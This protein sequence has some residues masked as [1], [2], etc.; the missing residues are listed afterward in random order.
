[1]IRSF[2][3]RAVM[4]LGLLAALALGPAQEALTTSANTSGPVLSP[5]VLS[6]QLKE[7]GH[8][9]TDE[10]GVPHIF[11]RNAH[12]LYFM[13]GYVQARDRLFQMDVTRR[14]ASGTLAELLG[15]DALAS[16]VEL[17]TLGLRRAAERSAAQLS[18][19]ARRELEAYTDGINAYIEQAEAKD[20]L[21]PAYGALELTQV[22]PWSV[23]DSL[24][25]AKALAFR[26]SF[27]S[28]ET[29]YTE[30]FLGYSE[31][32]R[33]TG[34]DGATLFNQDLFR[35]EPANETTVLSGDS[36]TSTQLRRHL[37]TR[38]PSS[39][40]IDPTTLEL[41]GDYLDD[42]REISM[43]QPLLK[44]RAIGSNWFVVSG[45]HTAS[46]HPMLA[47]DP[48]LSLTNPAT[49]YEMDQ[50]IDNGTTLDTSGV[51]F[52]GV[53][54]VVLGQT[55]RVAWG[56][57]N[58][59]IDETDFFQEQITQDEQG[60][61]F[62]V[63]RGEREPVRVIPEQYRINRI[64]DDQP[65]NLAP[66]PPGADVPQ[67]TLVAPRHGPIVQ[68]DREA[69][70][71]VSVQFTGF[72]A[73]QEVET[74][75][76]WNRAEGLDDF[77][78]GLKTFDFGSQNWAYAD[79]EGNIAYFASG[80]VPLREDLQQGFVDLIP[81]YLVR[82]G[83]GSL[84]HEWIPDDDP[85]PHQ[86]IP[87]ETLPFEEMPQ[88]VN[89]EKG[90]IVSANNDPLGHTLDND[91]LN[92]QRPSGEGLFYLSRTY[93]DGFRAARLTELIQNEIEADGT[94]S[95]DDAKAIMSDVAQLSA[96][97]LVPH[98]V[99]AL[100][101]ALAEDAPGPL[102]Q[103]ARDP[104][105]AQIR[106]LLA[107]W[108]YT[109]PTGLPS[110]FDEG[111]PAGTPPSP[112]EINAS[113]AATIANVWVPKLVANTVDGALNAISP[114]LPKPTSSGTIRALIHQLETFPENRGVGASGLPLFNVPD[115]DAPAPLERDLILLT[116]LK[117]ALE[118]LSGDA[119]ASAFNHSQD[120]RDYRWG[121]LHRVT[122]NHVA[123]LGGPFRI[124]QEESF[125]TDGGFGV[126]DASSFGIRADEPSDFHFD[127]GPARR[128]ISVLKPTGIETE[129]VIPGGQSGVP[130]QTH[131][132]DQ[133][134]LWLANRFHPL[135][136]DPVTIVDNGATWQDFVPVGSSD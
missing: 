22:E 119:F 57:T 86:A 37:A 46:G 6:E 113:I 84:Q 32:L 110:G 50:K 36:A 107:N 51:A 82:N 1:M 92:Q 78:A 124:P 87:F 3:P 70:Q 72:Y 68:M 43:F 44:E 7:Q 89:P 28:V 109:T 26:L 73:T 33:G 4:A 121:K 116:S 108:D 13:T 54:Y 10:F 63:F 100:E 48:H 65:N 45:E 117:D 30:A 136:T 27:D 49:F 66:A 114:R 20:R 56:A 133:L 39:T 24:T 122:F 17:R 47:N 120:L 88:T 102:A 25:V 12:D 11:A 67:A 99:N 128:T 135:F 15:P 52:P 34:I 115:M 29:A 61:L 118:A 127:S 31:A 104:R 98:L 83:A 80:E 130:G 129:Q 18:D 96:R 90:F 123:Q 125:P 94:V 126:V 8:V 40:S 93:S 106:D 81:P 101:N 14:Q 64:G 69:G 19:A 53:P 95:V 9:V 23:V 35:S 41:M 59:A 134:P 91:P 38:D 16:D 132:G 74:F 131:F 97:R 71:A 79:V 62:T 85:A 5:S 42:V 21:P 58:N 75:R 103:F 76:T 111:Q 112:R 60:R 2:A 55:D 77:K 105:L